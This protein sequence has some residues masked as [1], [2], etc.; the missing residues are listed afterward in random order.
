MEGNFI[1]A[2][3][4]N[5]DGLGQNFTAATYGALAAYLTPIFS[6]LFVL[7]LVFWGFQFWQ[8]H[9]EGNVVAMAFRLFRI[10]AV[11]FLATSWGPLQVAVYRIANYAP[12]YISNTIMLNNIVNPDNGKAMTVGTVASD[13]S[14]IYAIA[15]KTSVKIEQANAASATVASPVTDDPA[16]SAPAIP[17]PPAKKAENPLEEKLT[18]TIQAG[19]V[20]LS[21]GVFVGYAIFLMV[22]AKIA[23]WVMLSL[24]PIFIIMLMFQ[25]PS[26]FF[27]GW[28]TVTFQVVLVPIFLSTFLSFYILGVRVSI[29]ALFKVV[30]SPD[31]LP[32][33]MKEAA[34]MVLICLAGVFLLAQIV[35]LAARIASGTQ[36]WMVSAVSKIGSAK[37][38]LVRNDR[39]RNRYFSNRVGAGSA[40]GGLTGSAD[41]TETV[42]RE[43]QDRNAAVTRQGGNR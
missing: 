25:M 8:G 17:R 7:Y 15:V 2:L 33:T 26:R 6:G 4:A 3:S 16:T 5:I 10:A 13:M 32:I 11:F 24:A 20:W 40:S 1:A 36:E 28:L 9:G 19:I 18:S 42:L 31:D 30:M 22:F 14:T 27:S 41:P 34:P 29:M 43:L 39:G 37:I 35:P 21:A 12:L 23:L 38:S